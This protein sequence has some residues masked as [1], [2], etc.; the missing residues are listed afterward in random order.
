MERNLGIILAGLL[1][2][3]VQAQQPKPASQSSESLKAR[4]TRSEAE[5][6]VK[7]ADG[8]LSAA[9][10]RWV[11]VEDSHTKAESIIANIKVGTETNFP[12]AWL[13]VAKLKR[14]AGTLERQIAYNLLMAYNSLDEAHKAFK[15]L[16]EEKPSI[17]ERRN[18]LD[19]EGLFRESNNSL[20]TS[21]DYFE[22][23]GA[24]LDAASVIETL[25]ESD[26]QTAETYRKLRR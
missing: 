4:Y 1:A 18:S 25:A 14:T 5:Y 13:N 17:L 10:R 6:Y 7:A 21:R 12:T 19:Y 15:V 16:G 3:G 8:Y 20:R 11:V 24:H 26:R 23:A 2:L 9:D 22:S